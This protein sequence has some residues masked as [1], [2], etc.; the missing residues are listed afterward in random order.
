MRFSQGKCRNLF[1]QS[2]AVGEEEPHAPHYRLGPMGR[3]RALQSRTWVLVDTVRQPCA[4]AA[5]AS[6][7]ILGCIRKRVAIRWRKV[8]PL[9]CSALLRAQLP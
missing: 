6:N 8:I 7:S 4:L 3:K 9:H 1:V 5:R 2:P